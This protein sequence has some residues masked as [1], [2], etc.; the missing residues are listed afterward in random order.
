MGP[1][2]STKLT[3]R[4]RFGTSELRQDYDMTL[5]LLASALE[6]RDGSV[7]GHSTRVADLSVTLARRMGVSEA[8]LPQ[9][10]R[11]ALVHDVGNLRIP[12]QILQKQGGLTAEEWVLVHMHPF[13]GYEMLSG[14]RYLVPALDIAYC[15]H[16]KWDGS[17][18]PRGLFGDEIPLPARIF[19]IVDVWDSMT[20]ERPYHPAQRKAAAFEYI[21]AQAGRH[22]DPA[23]VAQFLELNPNLLPTTS[24]QVIS[25]SA[26]I[27]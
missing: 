17:G 11:G 20:T 6:M 26:E 25:A 3:H 16:E 2:A 18:Y 27:P 7:R 10:R 23:V 4:L 19:A 14:I 21:R 9:I 22:F 8:R 5:E 15:H 13:Y 12:E 1:S 24:G